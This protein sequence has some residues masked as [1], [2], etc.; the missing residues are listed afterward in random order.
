MSEGTEGSAAGSASTPGAES[1]MASLIRSTS[2]IIVP[3][4]SM[5]MT[6]SA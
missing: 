3:I 2:L 5:L 4:D 1:R 6:L